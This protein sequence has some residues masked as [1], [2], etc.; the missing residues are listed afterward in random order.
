MKKSLTRD[1]RIRRRDDIKSLFASSYF[2]SARGLKL[3]YRENHRDMTRILVT[4]GRRF[5]N[6]VRR[7]YIKRIG[8]EIFRGMKHNIRG[9]FDIA[10][11][12][13]PG[14]YTYDDRV[15]QVTMLLSRSMLLISD[16]P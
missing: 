3:M 5:G 15:N 16:K 13:Y 2:V 4:P 7:N 1:E 11:V 6:A 14:S 8:R 9:G 12:F 10:F